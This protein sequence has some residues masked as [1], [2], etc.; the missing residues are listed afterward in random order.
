MF[1]FLSFLGPRPSPPSWPPLSEATGALAGFVE[2]RPISVAKL[3]L[4][5]RPPRCEY[6]GRR[7]P[8]M[9]A[10][11]KPVP[12]SRTSALLY[13][14]VTQS[15]RRDAACPSGAGTPKTP[16]L[17]TKLFS[18]RSCFFFSSDSSAADNRASQ[19]WP[20][21]YR[22]S[23]LSSSLQQLALHHTTT[24]YTLDTVRRMLQGVPL[25][26]RAVTP[27]RR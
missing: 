5:G 24:V 23:S 15:R 26:V 2:G 7:F 20:L 4:P 14:A 27:V 8:K 21:R 11:G 9:R 17:T 16:P 13:D 19:L 3:F 6:G 22:A 1:S 10:G 12:N 18:V 25:P